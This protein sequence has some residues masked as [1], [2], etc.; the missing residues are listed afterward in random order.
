MKDASR[1]ARLFF[2]P[3]YNMDMAPVHYSSIQSCWREGG[4]GRTPHLAQVEPF[5]ASHV[6][7]YVEIQRPRP[8]Q[9]ITPV[10]VILLDTTILLS[11]DD[12]AYSRAASTVLQL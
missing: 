12:R 6:V 2:E 5:V 10:A 7:N 8:L 9:I 3:T 1:V 11:V 4:G